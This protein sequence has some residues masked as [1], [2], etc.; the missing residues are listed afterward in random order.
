MKCILVANIRFL[1][2]YNNIPVKR[3]FQGLTGEVTLDIEI[4]LANEKNSH[5]NAHGTR[6]NPEIL[7]LK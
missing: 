5:G 2:S 4:C 6:N 3:P 7:H 1:A